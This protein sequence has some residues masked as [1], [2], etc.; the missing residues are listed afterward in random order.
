MNVGL[1]IGVACEARLAMIVAC[2]VVK[3]V[4]V[5]FF[6]VLLS[7]TAL[8]KCVVSQRIFFQKCVTALMRRLCSKNSIKICPLIKIVPLP[9]LM[10]FKLN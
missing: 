7:P 8:E 10:M 5:L 2:E 1:E 3:K 4:I 6:C 9:K